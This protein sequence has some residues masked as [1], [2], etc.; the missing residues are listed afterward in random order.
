[1][2]ARTDIEARVAAPEGSHDPLSGQVHFGRSGGTMAQ[3]AGVAMA[4]V[5]VAALA[6]RLVG[7][8]AKPLVF[9]EAFS[10]LIAGQP[11]SALLDVVARVDPHPPL[12]YVLLHLWIGVVGDNEAGLRSLSVLVSVG[13]VLVTFLWGRRLMGLLPAT[14]AAVMLGLAPPAVAAG[15]EARMYSLLALTSMGSW[16]AFDEAMRNGEPRRWALYGVGTALMLYTH[17]FGILVWA[18]QGTYLALFR[19]SARQTRA[20]SLAGAGVLILMLP[21]LKPFVQQVASGRAWPAYRGAFHLADLGSSLWGMIVGGPIVA[22]EGL[23]GWTIGAAYGPTGIPALA[24]I[25]LLT[26]VAMVAAGWRRTTPLLLFAVLG[27]W[28]MTGL[29][30]MRQNIFSPRYLLFTIPPLTL[31]LGAGVVTMGRTARQWKTWAAVSLVGT[32]LASYGLHLTSLLRQQRLDDFDWRAVAAQLS[33]ARAD[34]AFVF[35][36]G[37]SAIPVG[38]YARGP[39]ERVT[40]TPTARGLRGPQGSELL[41][42]ITTLRLHP[43]IWILS[44]LPLPPGTKDLM[45]VL[46]RSGYVVTRRTILNRARIIRFD[47]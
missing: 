29:V 25:L 10:A 6:L 7:L 23:G 27:P 2:A 21:W 1:V 40:M 12:Y 13:T 18:S 3:W 5:V 14:V 20:W 41:D 31:L 8:Q 28:V 34:A 47:R 11:L 45:D 44:I 17:H 32:I 30:S 43:Q 24:A 4:A 15:Q 42:V 9:D 46:T 33:S 26:G 35:I 19:A 39:Q 36:P 16:W 22:A 37:F 38:Y